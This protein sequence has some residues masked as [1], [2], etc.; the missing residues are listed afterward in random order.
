MK[1]KIC[2]FLMLCLNLVLG[3]GYAAFIIIDEPNAN[4]NQLNVKFDYNDG[5]FT[6]DYYYTLATGVTTVDETLV[7]E[8]NTDS[9]SHKFQGW[10]STKT[11]FLA[12]GVTSS[13]VDLSTATFSGGETLYAQYI[14]NDS[15]NTLNASGTNNIVPNATIR[16]LTSSSLVSEVNLTGSINLL[17][18]ATAAEGT[19]DASE[20]GPDVNVKYVSQAKVY[21]VLSSDIV[22]NSGALIQLN[23]VIGTTSGT[24]MHQLIASEN[25]TCL[26]LNGYNITIKNG[27]T[28]NGYGIIF[29]TKDTGGII[30]E[31]GGTI[32]TPF[33]IMDFKGGSYTATGYN[34]GVAPFNNYSCPYLSCEVLFY[35]GSHF[36]GEA[37]LAANS[38]KF[39]TT[40]NLFGNTTDSFVQL[41]QGYII[42][43]ATDYL[44]NTKNYQQ[45]AAT[46]GMVDI[47]TTNYR[48]KLIFTDNPN[49]NLVSIK[50]KTFPIVNQCLVSL[51]TLSL[52]LEVKV[53]ITV[54]AV[55]NMKYVDFPI[56]SFLD[57]ELHNTRLEMGISLVCMPSST[58]YVDKDSSLYFKN[59]E[60]ASGYR[61][62]ARLT[63]LDE[64]PM[65][66]YYVNANGARVVANTYL[67]NY[68]MY[69]TKPAV[70]KLDGGL[71]FDSS[72]IDLSAPFSYYSIGGNI[73]CSKKAIDSLKLN[74]N[75]IKATSKYFFPIFL[76]GSGGTTD[77]A[78]RYYTKPILSNGKAFMQIG[79]SSEIVE[80]S[81]YDEDNSI[82]YYNEKYYYYSFSSASFTQN[83]YSNAY[84]AA[85]V[86]TNPPLVA[87]MNEKYQNSLG[88]YKECQVVSI[89][90]KR[91]YINDSGQNLLCI[92][93][94]FISIAS[95]PLPATIASNGPSK[96]LE[97]TTVS[98]LQNKFYLSN[99]INGTQNNLSKIAFNQFT[100]RWVFII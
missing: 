81:I 70:I 79:S 86:A 42:R 62:Y 58:I 69:S 51:N 2:F 28:L 82:Y 33:C 35:A 19:Y 26:D 54:T 80:A 9:A 84:D 25:F 99:G 64:Y 59:I 71:E 10:Y 52:K 39:P 12:D 92:N 53:L 13:Y 68:L 22:I 97:E 15:S 36:N 66:Y 32:S 20:S 89:D 94:A 45:L 27:G 48:E 18:G 11:G 75:Y 87:R 67:S 65:D 98:T 88:V 1:R 76:S 73:N 50:G 21:V 60:G 30:V 57:I 96:L 31:S 4:S 17:F 95:V 63:T 46:F 55:V 40:V 3:G 23:S 77:V 56:S 7:P 38:T 85:S 14:S 41:N 43:R 49:E 6:D 34:N 72:N 78:G 61:I 47:F 74:Q 90:D 8:S 93:G 16:Y 24:R 44:E 83:V 100:N 5:G 37:A 29:N 91:K